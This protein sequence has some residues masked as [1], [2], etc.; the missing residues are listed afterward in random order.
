MAEILE[1][2]THSVGRRRNP[3]APPIFAGTGRKTLINPV[4]N[5]R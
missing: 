2:I 3:Q 5:A 1:V 4:E